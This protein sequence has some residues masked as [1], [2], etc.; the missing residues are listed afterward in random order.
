MPQ[1]ADPILS[2][3]AGQVPPGTDISVTAVTDVT[4]YYTLDGS[5]PT[6]AGSK[7]YV[8]GAFDNLLDYSGN[9]LHIKIIGTDDN[10][11]N[12]PSNVVDASFYAVGFGGAVSA[13]YP[14]LVDTAAG[15]GG[16]VMAGIGQSG[17][18]GAS[19]GI[20]RIGGTAG[21]DVK[22]ET[23]DGIGV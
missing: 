18:D 4:F 11:V 2:A 8:A 7:A 16:A 21:T 3:T 9:N 20:A 10:N 6:K 15:Q 23:G 5:T 14:A 13:T 22:Y 1:V 19:A 12:T 17:A